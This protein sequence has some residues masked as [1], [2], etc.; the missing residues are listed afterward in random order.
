MDRIDLPAR[1]QR[2]ATIPERYRTGAPGRWLMNDP[3]LKGK[4]WLHQAK[5]M[6]AAAQGKN[7]I[8]S[9]GTASGKSL[10]FQSIAYRTLGVD[11]EA[12]VMVFYP[13]KALANDQ[14]ES[15]RESA[16]SAGYDR[17]LVDRID[18]SVPRHERAQ[19]LR[20]ARIV[21]MTP[22]VCHA[23]MMQ[24]ISNP[25]HAEFISRTAL[26]I[27]DEAHTLEGVFG[28]N[29]A[30]LFRRICAVRHRIL[31]SKKRQAKLQVI[32]ASAT[33][34][35]PDSH[36]ANL[37][38]MQYITV[39]ESDNGSP[40]SA[41][42][43]IHIQEKPSDKEIGAILRRLVDESDDG[44]FIVF[45]DSRMGAERIA[46]Q[47]DR[48]KHI[49]PYRSGYEPKDRTAIEDALRK[50]SL[51]GVVSTSALEL[52]I[53]IPHFSVGLN[54]GVPHSRKS[55]RQRLGR[56]GR[57]GP[58]VFGIIAP[59]FAFN[60]FGMTLMDYY[61]ESVEP[62]Y[63]YLNN[64]FMQYA[65]ARCLAEELEMLGVGG[66]KRVPGRVSWPDGFSEKLD[67]AYAGS[68]SARPR[69]YDQI[70]N[71]GGDQPHLNYPLRGIAEETFTVGRG[72]PAGSVVRFEQL[73]LQQA[74]REAFPGAT[75]LSRAR[76][77]R[78]QE[79]RN[80]AFERTIRVTPSSSFRSPKPL[81]RTYVNLSLDVESVVEGH[82][83]SSS[84]GVL[85]EC[86]LQITERVEGYRQGDERFLYKELRQTKRGM[87]PKTRDFRTTGVV[88]RVQDSWF[89]EKGV[90]ETV[91]DALRDLIL[92]EYSISPNDVG[93]AATNVSEIRN[94]RRQRL[95]D[96]VVLFDSTHGSLRLTEPAYTEFDHL[97][98]RLSRSVEMTAPN[99]HLLSLNTIQHLREWFSRLDTRSASDIAGLGTL[100][101]A[102]PE[103]WVHVF[104]AGSLVAY[105]DSKDVL[106]D[107]TITG[108]QLM[109][110]GDGFQ[111][112]YT[113]QGDGFIASIPADR[114]EAVGEN[115]DMVYWNPKTDEC[116]ESFDEAP[117]STIG[118]DLGPSPY[119]VGNPVE[120][121]EMF[122]GRAVIMEKIK[123][124]LGDNNHAN[125]ILLEG[126]RRTGKTS[127]LRQLGKKETLPGW[128]P[129]YCSLQ[130]VDS[131]ATADIFRLLTLRTGWT[132]ADVGIETWIPGVPQDDSG[133]PYKFS[134]RSALGRALADGHPYEMLEIYLSAAIKAAQ[135]RRILLMLD[136]FDKLQEGIDSGIT[137]AQV[138]ENIRHLLQH[139]PGLGAII[140]GSRRLKRL[141][142]EYWSALFGFGY[143]VGVSALPR[144]EAE[145]LVTEPV[146][147]Q[148]DYDHRARDRVVELCGCHPFLVQSLCSRVFDQA[149][150]GNKRTITVDIVERASNEMVQD[151]EHFHT[152]WGYAGSE[153]RRLILALCSSF[154][155]GRQAIGLPQLSTK[156]DE[157]GVS[158]PSDDDLADDV[159]E[160]RELEMLEFDESSNGGTYRLSVPLMA[161]WIE[162]NVDFHDLLARTV[163]ETSPR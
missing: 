133:K 130:D 134:F 69:E 137:S 17:A 59:S 101:E 11:D 24:E 125:V 148:L 44:S 160:L 74:V 77:W 140:T 153:R 121:K 43:V 117:E 114:V 20:D 46:A 19:K 78:V 82:L 131:I 25:D 155:N 129:V 29:F 40:R 116:R 159:T 98:Q 51:R 70:F 94:G 145:R 31:Q 106:R 68:P 163:R 52:G 35:A 57:H 118:N 60:R 67:F 21:L 103:G 150:T 6:R 84:Q 71:I 83:Q 162:M 56:I 138:P 139:L 122:Y 14:W 141:R 158:L 48:P 110:T 100:D 135:P 144:L 18:G 127:I 66:R 39:A 64:R 123:R 90:K 55:F 61:R 157:N 62:S 109:Q 99:E 10:I 37:T 45:R 50:G 54:I 58:G 3:K 80:T 124:Q 8:V 41:Q 151:N 115:W 132:L 2:L 28:S 105:R 93:S 112:V 42:A 108:R 149:A 38:G 89:A 49:N 63:L 161:M 126:N 95:T 119:I 15:W 87:T 156:L 154:A 88:L 79:W 4:L 147:G 5:A 27:I 146:A 73:S 96:T 12:V 81:I 136:E 104:E 33:I 1:A 13:L 102:V 22:D 128:V 30:Y 23:W 76:G 7:I 53:D 111:L 16:E 34:D 32:A 91:A 85:A 97:L 142:N 26:I 75:Y 143:R 120:Q 86:Q 152:L 65:H 36:L 72:G 9:T 107:I 92:S 47:V 113:Y